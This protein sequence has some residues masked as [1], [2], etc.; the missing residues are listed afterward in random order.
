MIGLNLQNL[1]KQNFTT[2][3][4]LV[5][6][7]AALGSFLEFYDFTIFGFYTI[8]FAPKIF[9]EHDK[10]PTMMYAYLILTF[11]VLLKPFG[12]FLSRRF[13]RK[14]DNKRILVNTVLITGFCSFGMGLIPT[15]KL[16]GAIAGIS[17]ALLRLI[18][19][20]TSGVEFH[21]VLSYIKESIPSERRN[22]SLSGVL[23]GAEFGGLLAI[24]IN[25]S[26]NHH[27]PIRIVESWGWR[28]PFILGGIFAIICYLC[29]FGFYRTL[30]IKNADNDS[31]INIFY[32]LKHCL[33]QTIVLASVIG[34]NS[35]L[36]INCIIYMPILLYY[37]VKLSY[38]TIS[39][40][41]FR[42]S[43]FSIAASFII[44]EFAK[45]DFGTFKLGVG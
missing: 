26:I 15:H 36:F 10:M 11:S 24:I 5:I 13:Y 17:M 28:I 18:Q 39:I 6:F 20:I 29:R 21:S 19:G 45:L 12:A 7:V 31:E 35:T 37:Q 41:I 32:T 4:K 3:E 14:T 33:P 8:Y 9:H 2:N 30:S 1:F 25:H 16:V 22:F 42:G 23:I 27:F 34:I 38:I 43:I 44:N 40:L